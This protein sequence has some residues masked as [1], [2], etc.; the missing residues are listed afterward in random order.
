MTPAYTRPS[1]TKA[2]AVGERN[3]TRWTRHLRNKLFKLVPPTE[4]I[5]AE[6]G[7]VNAARKAP[8]DGRPQ[9]ATTRLRVEQT[10]IIQMLQ[11]RHL[12]GTGKEISQSEVLAV[13]MAE[14][15]ERTLDHAEF[16]ASVSRAGDL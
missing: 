15:L 10:A 1:K 2:T 5:S 6:E 3:R 8:W 16:S 14:G 4:F 9:W 7:A 12:R 11:E 13:L